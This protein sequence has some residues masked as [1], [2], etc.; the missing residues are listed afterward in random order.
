MLSSDDEYKY[1]VHFIDNLTEFIWYYP[2]HL[3]FDYYI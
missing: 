2:I 1:Y 3:K